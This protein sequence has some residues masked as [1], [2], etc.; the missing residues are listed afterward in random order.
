VAY[1]S[2]ASGHGRPSSELDLLFVHDRPVTACAELVTA[3]V[4]LH[5]GEGLTLDTEVRHDVKLCASFDDIDQATALAGFEAP[6]PRVTPVSDDPG[7]LNAT[8]FRLRLFLSAI[9]YSLVAERLS[10]TVGRLLSAVC[11]EQL[12]MRQRRRKIT[13]DDRT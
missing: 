10:L 12:V 2:H 6:H 3:V 8:P 7:E 1:G 13:D 11:P 9:H 4:A 5:H